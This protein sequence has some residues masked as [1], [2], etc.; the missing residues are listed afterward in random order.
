[1]NKLLAALVALPL[2]AGAALAA[3]PKMPVAVR[4]DLKQALKSAPFYTG[5][6]R[7]SFKG[8]VVKSGN[9]YLATVTLR[10]MGHMGPIYVTPQPATRIGLGISTVKFNATTGKE[11]GK[12]TTGML[13]RAL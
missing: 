11:K 10:G 2:F 1:M 3:T 6:V 13:Y 4:A 8:S 5:A 9:S 12:I 7:P